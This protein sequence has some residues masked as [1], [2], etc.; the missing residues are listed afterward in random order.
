MPQERVLLL[1]PNLMKPVVT[2]IALDYLGWVLKKNGYDVDLIDL[3][4]SSD[5]DKALEQYFNID[6]PVAVG[7]TVRNMDDAYYLR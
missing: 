4:F 5:I 7:I 6:F 3:S 2:P 1:N